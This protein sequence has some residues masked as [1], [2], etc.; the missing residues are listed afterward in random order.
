M[1]RPR[2]SPAW[3]S[4]SRSAES[5]Y[6]RR[7]TTPART[8]PAHAAR[9]RRDAFDLTFDVAII[10][11]GLNGVLELIGG[12]L[13]LLVT[14]TVVQHLVLQLTQ[15]E[16]AEDPRDW[17]ANHLRAFADRLGASSLTYGAIYLL[18]HGIVKVVLVV[19]LLRE[20]MWAYPMMIVVLLGFIGYQ[21]YRMTISPT[22]GLIALT[23]FDVVIVAMTG[24]E[25]AR[26]R[27]CARLS[28]TLAG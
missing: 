4:A 5:T 9:R 8:V 6:R 17:V 1:P 13:L 2:L 11:K 15:G 28:G 25:W 14:P 20:R 27:R 3:V 23:L 10:A 12:V 18:V 26:H 22:A 16:L 7:V 19:E 24:V 21:L